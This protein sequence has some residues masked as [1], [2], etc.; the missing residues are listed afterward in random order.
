[1]PSPLTITTGMRFGRLEI[2]SEAERL[3]Y[4]HG[5]QRQFVCKCECGNIITTTLPHLRAGNVASCGCLQSDSGRL[6]ATHGLT[7]SHLYMVWVNMKTRCNNPN[8]SRFEN[9]GGRGIQV[10]DEWNESF[11]SFAEWAMSNGFSPAL[12]LD[13][14]D[15]DG[16]YCPSNCRF[17]TRKQQARNKRS[18]RNLTL[19]G[20]TQPM[21]AWA[22]EL[23]LSY[24][25]I[26]HR[27]SRGWSDERTLTQP[28]RHPK[29]LGSCSAP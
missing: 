19:N 10:C 9:H 11:D 26:S 4:K 18:N 14:I 6:R 15:N 16:N 22:E 17:V 27:I 2:V 12:Q 13:R 1:M 3:R 29:T 23:G 21:S 25:M 5:T 7:G 8:A 24:G 20:K 28:A